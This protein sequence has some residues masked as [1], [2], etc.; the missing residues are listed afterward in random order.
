M[1][2]SNCVKLAADSRVDE[3]HG[4]LRVTKRSGMVYRPVVSIPMGGEK[5]NGPESEYETKEADEERVAAVVGKLRDVPPPRREGGIKHVAAALVPSTLAN[6]RQ[7]LMSLDLRWPLWVLCFVA[8]MRAGG[9]KGA[10]LTCTIG[11][12]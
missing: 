10:G 4:S 3:L 8:A 11:M 12:Q 7:R 6:W 5:T 9:R 1:S 2:E